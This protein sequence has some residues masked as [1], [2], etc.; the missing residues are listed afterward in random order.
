MKEIKIFK[1]VRREYGVIPWWNQDGIGQA[2][3]S[4]K[5]KGQ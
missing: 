3:Y 2:S 5:L 1:R 4:N